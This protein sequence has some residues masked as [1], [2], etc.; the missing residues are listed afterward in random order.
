[1]NVL[2]FYSIKESFWLCNNP[3]HTAT[4]LH[5]ETNRA[6]GS[7]SPP[8]LAKRPASAR[9][10]RA[11]VT[12][13][14][15]WLENERFKQLVTDESHNLTSNRQAKLITGLCFPE[16][17]SQFIGAVTRV[18]L[19]G[20]FFSFYPSLAGAATGVTVGLESSRPEL[21]E[22][23]AANG[24]L[25]KPPAGKQVGVSCSHPSRR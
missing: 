23:A 17:G 24:G 11:S 10:L 25:G 5:L 2:W 22:K 18:F 9:S 15:K 14:N 20:C 12:C 8:P 1:M 13:V 3:R 6:C 7:F 21:S 4:N 19:G 16:K